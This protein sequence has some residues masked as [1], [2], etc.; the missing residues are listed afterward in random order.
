LR[1]ADNYRGTTL[2]GVFISDTIH[3]AAKQ[4]VTNGNAY[5]RIA[6]PV[7]QAENLIDAADHSQCRQDADGERVDSAPGPDRQRAK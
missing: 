2:P 6:K 7:E 1:I 5:G 3:A 4:P